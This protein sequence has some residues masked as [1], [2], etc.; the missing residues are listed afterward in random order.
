M[1]VQA[2]IVRFDSAPVNLSMLEAIGKAISHCGPDGEASYQAHSIWMVYRPFHTT[3]ESRCQQQPYLAA[4]G[5]VFMFDGRV[6]NR[7]ELEPLLA[8]G[9]GEMQS[10]V[11][12][13]V[14]CFENW[15]VNTFAKIIGDWALSIWNP[16]SRTLILAKDYFGV[17]PLYYRID[18]DQAMWCTHLAPLVQLSQRP[19]TL[20][21]QYIAGYLASYPEPHLTPYREIYAVPPG[22][23]V[24]ICN[25]RTTTETH[26]AP[27]PTLQIRYKTD[28]DY[29]QHFLHLFRQAVRRRLRSDSPVLAELSGGFDS[30]SIVCMADDILAN[31]GSSSLTHRLDTLSYYDPTEPRGDDQQY[32]PAVEKKRSRVGRHI[33]ISKYGN[34]FSLEYPDFVPVPGFMGGNSMLATDVAE[35]MRVQGNRV[36]LSGIGGDELLGGVPDPTP[37]LADLLRTWHLRTFGRQ[38]FAWSLAKRRPVT[39]LLFQAVLY[40]LPAPLRAHLMREATPPAWVHKSFAARC[41]WRRLH[42]GAAQKTSSYLPSQRDYLRGMHVLR[43]ILATGSFPAQLTQEV[44][45]PFLDRTLIDFLLAIPKTQLLR[46]G[47]RRS[48]MRRALVGLVPDEILSRKTKA[49]AARSDMVAIA[50]YQHELEALFLSPV[51]AHLGYIEPLVIR[52]SLHRAGNGDAPLLIPLMSVIAVELWLRDVLQRRLVD[53]SFYGASVLHMGGARI[54]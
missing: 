16:A 44:R 32:Y 49:A 22:G 50:S 48:L 11:E 53:T 30:S 1:S 51:S 3:T 14:A 52:E 18:K 6:D 20:N 39:Q 31:E 43:A 28:Q 35:V 13:V 12:L 2:G 41:H 23:V 27:N 34:S 38:L 24:R 9:P 36:V 15:G 4:S 54:M 17:C 45:Y 21:D 42:L 46:P 37:E 8:H 25:G 29:E 26:W 10:D 40:L 5:T 47:D 7:D 19:L 33:D